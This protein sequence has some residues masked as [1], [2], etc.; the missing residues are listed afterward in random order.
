MIITA[1]LKIFYTFALGITWLISEFGDVSQNNAI[2]SSIVTF[3]NYYVALDAFV[4]LSVIV[5]IIAFDLALEGAVYLYKLLR[6]AYSKV[7]FIN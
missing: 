5:A 4:P 6:W 3:K 7:P 1:I 2:T